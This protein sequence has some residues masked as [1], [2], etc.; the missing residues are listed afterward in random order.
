MRRSLRLP[1]YRLRYAADAYACRAFCFE[2]IRPILSPPLSVMRDTPI[3]SGRFLR[4]RP[5]RHAAKSTPI[6]RLSTIF[7]LRADAMSSP[8]S[9]VTAA[10]YKIAPPPACAEKRLP[11]FAFS[12]PPLAGLA[13]NANI[14]PRLRDFAATPRSC[15]RRCP[16][17]C[18]RCLRGRVRGSIY[19]DF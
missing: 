1:A 10:G 19:H 13:K 4:R 15:R 3:S 2:A 16:H 12:P 5:A 17:R 6:S 18:A 9:S 7:T 14:R 11:L 8:L